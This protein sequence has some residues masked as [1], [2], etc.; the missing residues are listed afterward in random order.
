MPIEIKFRF[1]MSNGQANR[2]V[3]IYPGNLRRILTCVASNAVSQRRHFAQGLLALVSTSAQVAQS[4]SCSPFQQPIMIYLL[5]GSAIRKLSTLHDCVRGDQVGSQGAQI[6]SPKN[7]FFYLLRQI[8]L[9]T[10]RGPSHL[11]RRMLSHGFHIY[12]VFQPFVLSSTRLLNYFH[13]LR[14]SLLCF[15]VLRAYLPLLTSPGRSLRNRQRYLYKLFHI[16]LI[17]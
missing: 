8:L 10:Q 16:I 11:P 12:F 7:I 13:P 9:V 4:R 1:S 17:E 15:I 2:V 5:F 6:R 14:S 3:Y